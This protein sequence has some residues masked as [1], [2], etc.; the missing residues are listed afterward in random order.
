MLGVGQRL[1]CAKLM[2]EAIDDD[3]RNFSPRPRCC[4]VGVNAQPPRSNGA[5]MLQAIVFGLFCYQLITIAQAIGG[6]GWV[7]AWPA[8]SFGLVAL[9]YLGLGPAIM[10]KGPNGKGKGHNGNGQG[11]AV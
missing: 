7:L 11:P 9:G 10:G 8:A 1:A 5:P 6:A 4:I 3:A 2:D